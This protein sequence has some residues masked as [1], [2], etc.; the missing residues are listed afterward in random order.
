MASK[1]VWSAGTTKTFLD[2]KATKDLGAKSSSSFEST[3]SI[4]GPRATSGSDKV[5][6]MTELLHPPKRHF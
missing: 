3:A 2:L 6:W 1:M 5:Y 4:F